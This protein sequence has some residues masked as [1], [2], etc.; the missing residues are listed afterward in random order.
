MIYVAQSVLRSHC[1]NVE[2]DAGYSASEQVLLAQLF[3]LL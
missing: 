2:C 3:V 1:A